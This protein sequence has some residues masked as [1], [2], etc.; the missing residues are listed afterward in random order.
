MGTEANFD[1]I[2]V[3]GVKHSGTALWSVDVSGSEDFQWVSDSSIT[4]SGWRICATPTHPTLVVPTPFP[5]PATP[6]PTPYPTPAGIFTV[7]AGS[8]YCGISSSGRCVQ[9]HNYNGN[10]DDNYGNNEYCAFS[11]TGSANVHATRMGTEANF[12]YI[13]VDGVKHSGTALWSVDVSGSEDFQWVSDSSVTGSGWQ[14][15]ARPSTDESVV[16][17]SIPVTTAPTTAPNLAPL[18]A[19]TDHDDDED[20]ISVGWV[21]APA[22]LIMWCFCRWCRARQEED[23]QEGKSSASADHSAEQTEVQELSR[24]A[25][26]AGWSAQVDPS[27]ART[28]YQNTRT[29]QTSWELPEGPSGPKTAKC[30]ECLEEFSSRSAMFRHLRDDSNKCGGALAEGDGGKMQAMAEPIAVPAKHTHP[31][32]AES[33]P[34]AAPAPAPPPLPRAPTTWAQPVVGPLMGGAAVGSGPIQMATV[35]GT[36]PSSFGGSASAVILTGTVVNPLG[37]GSGAAAPLSRGPLSRRSVAHAHGLRVCGQCHGSGPSAG[38]FCCYC[39]A[40]M[41][42]DM[43]TRAAGDGDDEKSLAGVQAG[44]HTI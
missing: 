23:R 24:A 40:R 44:Q 32:W 25:V 30:S 41:D 12:D 2:A 26:L 20:E 43:D 21:W 22:F 38:Q 18:A 15:C 8:A 6:S 33:E 11:Y 27:T 5:T 10:D 7:S 16:V 3:G 4:G 29:N 34:A 1:Y 35:V 19:G 42:M 36:A 31:A 9:T 39:G 28:Y 14:I 37:S 17:P 13:T